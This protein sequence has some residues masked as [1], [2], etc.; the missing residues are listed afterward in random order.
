MAPSGRC[1]T[2][3]GT[4]GQHA[5]LLWRPRVACMLLGA[6]TPLSPLLALLL[7]CSGGHLEAIK[8]LLA[9]VGAL[10]AVARTQYCT[11]H[12]P[13]GHRAPISQT[14]TRCGRDP[15]CPRPMRDRC[16]YVW[17]CVCVGGKSYGVR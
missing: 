5:F 15:F 3:Q 17:V 10:R 4:V 12:T 14:R 2:V 11:T 13:R 16:T 7:A 9:K 1:D 8:L 6:L